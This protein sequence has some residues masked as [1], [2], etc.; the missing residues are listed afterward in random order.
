MR[1]KKLVSG[2]VLVSVLMVLVFVLASYDFE[3]NSKFPLRINFSE[4]ENLIIKNI[5]SSLIS[6]QKIL[7]KP[8]ECNFSAPIEIELSPNLAKHLPK[9]IWVRAFVTSQDKRTGVH[10]SNG[11]REFFSYHSGDGSEQLLILEADVGINDKLVLRLIPSETN[12]LNY[13]VVFGP[14]FVSESMAD[15]DYEYEGTKISNFWARTNNPNDDFLF[16]RYTSQKINFSVTLP[17]SENQ[18]W[19]SSFGIGVNDRFNTGDFFCFPDDNLMLID[20]KNHPYFL[21][22]G[23]L[24]W[25]RKID[26]LGEELI[27]TFSYAGPLKMSHKMKQEHAIFTQR[28]YSNPLDFVQFGKEFV[29]LKKTYRFNLNNTFAEVEVEGNLGVEN[30]TVVWVVEDAAYMDFETNSSKGVF[31]FVEGKKNLGIFEIFRSGRQDGSGLYGTPI[32][33]VRLRDRNLSNM[34]SKLESYSPGFSFAVPNSLKDFFNSN[35]LI[36]EILGKGVPF[37][38]TF[39]GEGGWSFGLGFFMENSLVKARYKMNFLTPNNFP[40]DLKPSS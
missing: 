17:N 31:S 27:V 14:I 22:L 38:Q 4:Y 29:S 21:Y 15:L 1:K 23:A 2:I 18:I 40:D 11:R 16:D 26:L 34:V 28:V 20:R 32:F 39:K 35:H 9:K 13:P 24:D 5:C 30:L 3:S 33:Q 19:E 8:G 10:F 36:L 7:I 12:I 6:N 37:S 25:R